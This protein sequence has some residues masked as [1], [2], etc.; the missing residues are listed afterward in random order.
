MA[1]D[2]KAL[3][4]RPAASD[5]EGNDRTSERTGSANP[6]AS[7]CVSRSTAVCGSGVADYPTSPQRVVGDGTVQP[8][9][10]LRD[11]TAPQRRQDREP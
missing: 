9:R 10:V 5:T 1:A 4:S 6:H 3:K 11:G 8:Y 2:D 7:P